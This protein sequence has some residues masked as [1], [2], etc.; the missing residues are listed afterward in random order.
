MF[1][2]FQS[3]A[4]SAYQARDGLIQQKPEHKTFA[5]TKSFIEAS[6]KLEGKHYLDSLRI[7]SGMGSISSQLPSTLLPRPRLKHA[8]QRVC[9]NLVVIRCRFPSIQRL[10]NG[11][12]DCLE[13]ALFN[14]EHLKH[15]IP[16]YEM[17][18]RLQM[19]VEFCTACH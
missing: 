6:V 10:L 7:R 19:F 15:R 5:L 9:I 18:F 12:K 2:S 8:F 17:V 16:L 13:D 4:L 14:L 1:V 11:A 3:S